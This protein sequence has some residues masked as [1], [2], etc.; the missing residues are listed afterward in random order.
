MS[1]EVAY[2]AISA[3]DWLADSAAMTHIARSRSDFTNYTEEPSEIEGISPGAVLHTRGQGSVHI[4][5]KVSTKVN[6]IK[7]CDVKH[8]PDALNNLIS[9]GRLTDKGNSATFNGTSVEFITQARVIFAQ[10][11][12]HRQL[13]CMKAWVTQLGKAQDFAVTVKGRS[14]DKWHQILRHIDINSIK[15]LKTNDLVTGLDIDETKEHSQCK[16]CIQGKQHVEPFP[17]KAEDTVNQIS[18]VTVSDIWRPAQTEGPSREWYFHSFT[19]IKYRYSA[20][21]FSNTKDEALRHFELYK[22][23]IETQ[24]GHKLKKFQSDNGG[25]YGNKNFKDFCGKHGIIIETTAPYSPAQNGIAEQ[26]NRTLLKHARAMIFAKN[27]PKT[28]WSEAVTYA[29]YI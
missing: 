25:E 21:Y 28:L 16:V 27:L 8:T 23:F 26:L 22:V 13:F 12:K 29:C 7:L 3:S 17:K 2:S 19:D 10:G 1:K 24:R 5:F 4:E 9:I 6:T 15:M 18:D 11:Q 14:W 20:I